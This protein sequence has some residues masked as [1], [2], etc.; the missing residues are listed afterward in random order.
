MKK[1]YAPWRTSYAATI[2]KN[3]PSKDKCP[4]C[5][6]A[7]T[8][9]PTTITHDTKDYILKQAEK[10]TVLLNLYP[11]NTGEL[12]HKNPTNHAS[13]LLTKIQNKDMPKHT[14]PLLHAHHDSIKKER[15]L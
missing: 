9:L 1:L 7:K 14:P 4:F 3:I 12:A 5:R 11:Y 8:S 15:T 13:D 10:C 2:N 6:A